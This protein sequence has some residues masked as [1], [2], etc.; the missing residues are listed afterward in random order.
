[1][2]YFWLILIRAVLAEI[3]DTYVYHRECLFYICY[4][5]FQG[6]DGCNPDQE[7]K[8]VTTVGQLEIEEKVYIFGFFIELSKVDSNTISIF[9]TFYFCTGFYLYKV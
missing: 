7:G 3:F 6:C 2:E 5:C 9:E 8:D 4:L 1:M